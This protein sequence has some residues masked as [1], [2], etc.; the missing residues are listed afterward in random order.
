MAIWEQ[1]QEWQPCSRT[2][3]AGTRIRKGT[4]QSGINCTKGEPILDIQ[5]CNGNSC[6]TSG[7]LSYHLIAD[8]TGMQESFEE[9]RCSL[10]FAIKEDSLRRFPPFFGSVL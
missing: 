5:L 1:W 7:E 3:G 2:C 6:G 4:C 8:S 9:Q 10:R